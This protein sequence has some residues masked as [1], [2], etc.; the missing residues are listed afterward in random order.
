MSNDFSLSLNGS[1]CRMSPYFV[2]TTYVS[3]VSPSRSLTVPCDA[4]TWVSRAPSSITTNDPWSSSTDAR[5][6][7]LFTIYATP[8][9]ASSAHMAANHHEPYM[10]SAT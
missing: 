3:V 8:A 5:L 7:R 4:D 9:A 1:V 6:M 10:V 2:L